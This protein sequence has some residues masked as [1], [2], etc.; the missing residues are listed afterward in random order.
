[1]ANKPKH[2]FCAIKLYFINVEAKTLFF[3]I[4]ISKQPN[5]VA[6][7]R[8]HVFGKIERQR[9]SLVEKPRKWLLS[10]RQ[11]VN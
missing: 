5:F 2:V 9:C 4:L 10:K 11:C 3:G 7:K 8:K 6:N 1:M